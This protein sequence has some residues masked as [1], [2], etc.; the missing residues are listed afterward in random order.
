MTDDLT[1]KVS[2]TA[3]Q[4][5]FYCRKEVWH[6][7]QHLKLAKKITRQHNSHVGNSERQS[8]QKSPFQSMYL[9]KAFEIVSKCYTDVKICS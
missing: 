3:L 7:N 1:Y 8:T 5:L 9:K 2:L 4:S 6:F